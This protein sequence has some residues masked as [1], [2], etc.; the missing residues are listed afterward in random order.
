MPCRKGAWIETGKGVRRLNDEELIRG[1][2]GAKECQGPFSE[3]VF[4]RTTSLFIWEHISTSLLG[5]AEEGGSQSK[6]Q[7]GTPRLIEELQMDPDC[8]EWEESEASPVTWK[9]PDLSPGGEWHTA[10][11]RNLKMA[12]RGLP[13]SD[14]EYEKGLRDLET[15]RKNYDTDGPR[16]TQLQLLWWEFPPEHWTEIREGS[17]MN[18]LTTPP[19]VI[20]DNADMDEAGQ[21]AAVEF[22]EE[23]IALGVLRPGNGI[24]QTTAPLF[25]VDKPGQPGQFRVIAD[26]LRGG[27]N[28]HIGADP[29]VL[30]RVTQIADQLYSGGYSAVIDA[31]KYFYQFRTSPG[32]YP[33]LGLKHPRTGDLYY[34]YG[35]PMG[36]SQ[37][38]ASACRKGYGFLRK[39]RQ[40]YPEFQGRP[41]ANCWWTGFS[42]KGYDPDLGYGLVFQHDQDQPCVKAWAFV[43]DFLIHGPTK[44]V[45]EQALNHF[46]DAALEAGMLCHPKK[47]VAPSQVVRYC[48][49][50]LDSREKPIMR[51]PRSKRERALAITEIILDNPSK[52]W[53]R[54]ALS[55]AAG[56]LES[57]VEGTPRR[58]GHTYL[59]ATHSTVHPPN[60]GTGLEAYLTTTTLPRSM[61][62]ELE[63]WR[64]FLKLGYGRHIR[65]RAA[66]TFIPAWGD[67]SGTGTGGTYTPPRGQGN[68]ETMRMWKGKWAPYVH[69]FSSNWRELQTL[70]LTLEQIEQDPAVQTQGTTVFYFTDNSTTYWVAASGSSPSPELHKLATAI[71]LK[72]VALGCHL[73]VI[74]VPG[75][76]MIQQGA[77]SLSAEGFGSH[78]STQTCLLRRSHRQYLHLFHLMGTS[79]RSMSTYSHRGIIHTVG[80]SV[81][82]GTN[83]GGP[84]EFSIGCQYGIRRLRWHGKSSASCWSAGQNVRTPHQHYF[85]FPGRCPP[86]GGAS[87]G[88]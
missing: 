55:V 74:H 81:V 43:D 54:L 69:H 75:L 68:S 46:L 3:G 65:P 12:V 77:D 9:P 29:T 83:N 73:E 88:P 60:A 20:H 33:Y 1:L 39:L 85:S 28:L 80:G 78:P 36:S 64:S 37:S 58:V 25:V 30:P 71:R 84:S 38:P 21:A 32:D 35:L 47:L 86:S 13:D 5:G 41:R 72:E 52:N 6:E 51:I 62:M 76:V 56:V 79:C 16:P 24:V 42:G 2:G 11:V 19:P 7:K 66:A 22:T 63:W 27:Q 4:R 34:Y 48:G 50:I 8:E 14:Q 59:R 44:E 49:F 23:L 17:T 67:G 70:L 53:S 82:G 26:M 10:R 40:Q 61:I 31:S 15:H 45:V 18:F 57:L 87:A